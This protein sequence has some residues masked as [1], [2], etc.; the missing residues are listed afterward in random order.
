MFMVAWR[1]ERWEGCLK[2][3][4][5][6]NHGDVGVGVKHLLILTMKHSLC[7]LHL[8]FTEG[9]FETIYINIYCTIQ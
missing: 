9:G 2:L 5:P 8:T 4:G 6:V 1:V 3:W 7:F